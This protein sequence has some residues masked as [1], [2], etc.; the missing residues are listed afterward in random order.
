MARGGVGS[1]QWSSRQVVVRTAELSTHRCPFHRAVS[2]ITPAIF[3]NTLSQKIPPT[4]LLFTIFIM[5]HQ[6]QEV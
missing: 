6:Y 3:S 4:N 5:N 2:N 1:V